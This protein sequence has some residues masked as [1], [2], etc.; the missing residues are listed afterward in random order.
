MGFKKAAGN[1]NR[2]D[3]TMQINLP[4]LII[5]WLLWVCIAAA[6]M[7]SALAGLIFGTIATVVLLGIGWML[8]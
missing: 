1:K 6:G 4:W 8:R 2:L 3:I 5:F 7:G